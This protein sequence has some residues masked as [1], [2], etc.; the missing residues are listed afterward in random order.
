MQSAVI[1]AAIALAVFLGYKTK[2]NTLYLH[3]LSAV[4]GWISSRKL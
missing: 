2:I 4:S 3:I 1:I